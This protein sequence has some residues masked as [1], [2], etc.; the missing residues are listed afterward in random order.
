MNRFSCRVG[1]FSLAIVWSMLFVVGCAAPTKDK[2]LSFFLTVSPGTMTNSVEEAQTMMEIPLQATGIFQS[3]R[4]FLR[5]P[6]RDRRWRP[7]IRRSPITNAR[8][9]MGP[10]P[11]RP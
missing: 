2:W 4:T 9:A 3:R 11:G 1:L 10:K 8:S 7:F 6:T 5:S